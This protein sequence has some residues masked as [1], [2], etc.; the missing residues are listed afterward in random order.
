VGRETKIGLLVGVVFIGLFGLILGGRAGSAAEEHA[1]LPVGKSEGH[2]TLAQT[3]HR[4]ID[5]FAQDRTLVIDGPDTAPSPDGA[6]SGE[7]S[8]PAPEPLPSEEGEP[9]ERMEPAEADAEDVGLVVFVPETV[10]TPMDDLAP[11]D[12]AGGDVDGEGV[13]TSSPPPPVE[14]ASRP[15]HTVRRGEN[16]TILARRYYGEEGAGLWRR[17][18][19]ANK[20]AVPDPHRLRQGQKLVIPRLPVERQPIAPDTAVAEAPDSAPSEAPPRDDVPSVTAD[21]LAQMLGSRS[22]LI[23]G[24]PAPPKTYTVR[25]GDTFYRIAR[26]LYGDGRYARLLILKNKHLVPDET[27]LQIG[28]RIVLLEG[29]EANPAFDS[30]VAQR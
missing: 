26:N 20:A 7:V 15:V 5:P 23:E 9:P 24:R 10:T 29:V 17:I 14:D 8:L 3:I 2:R 21:D 27:K 28:Q 25:K 19:E 6:V 16:L 11:G 1:P 22:D 4:T 13:D 30:K 12:D 18:W